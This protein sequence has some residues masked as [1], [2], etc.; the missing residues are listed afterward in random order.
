MLF[1]TSFVSRKYCLLLQS[2]YSIR[3]D[4]EWSIDGQA[5]ASDTSSFSPCH[6]N[7]SALRH[8]VVRSTSRKQQKVSFFT[9]R[10]V[11]VSQ[12]LPPVVC[13]LRMVSCPGLTCI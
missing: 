4:S 2:D 9:E 8:N 7:H 3:V 1:N 10:E 5:R 12:G 11:Q 6:M 13:H